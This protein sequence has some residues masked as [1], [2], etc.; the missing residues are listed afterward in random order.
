[1]NFENELISGLFVK[2]Y[3]RFFVDV[4][5]DKKIVTA[6]CPN[7]GS[8]Q[9]LLIKN[10]KVWLTKSNDP[11]RK[12]KYTLQIIECNGSKVGVN[13]HLTNKIVLD[14][15]NNNKIKNFKA[16]E[17]KTEVKFGDNTRFDFL[18]TES[19]S[20]KFIEVKNVTLSRTDKLAEFPDAVTSRGAKHI[21]ELIKAKIKGYDVYLMFVVQREDCHQFSIA[22]DIDPKYADLLSDAVKKNLNILCY[23]CKFS[24][25]GIKLN[26][27]IKIKI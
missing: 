23:D 12:L 17:I 10:N 19:N 6:H 5:I 2:R 14:G 3:K 7:T 11:K 27:E 26:K 24:S 21:D 4:I 8:M 13:T 18:I 20:K 15:L 9:G 22:R 25:K 16:I 1:M